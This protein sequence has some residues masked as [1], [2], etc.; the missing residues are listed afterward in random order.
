MAENECLDLSHRNSGRWRR[1]N[2][3]VQAKRDPTEVGAKFERYLYR[4]VRNLVKDVQFPFERLTQA[5][6]LGDLAEVHRIVREVRL[7]REYAQLFERFAS[8]LNGAG[9]REVCGRWL[10]AIVHRF[11][12]QFQHRATGAP[13]W[14]DLAEF[15]P[16]RRKVELSLGPRIEALAIKLVSNPTTPPRLPRRPAVERDANQKELLGQS[17]INQSPARVPVVTGSLS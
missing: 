11:F 5:A 9:A 17:L 10:W 7:H 2:G 3:L 16:Y 12:D 6:D 14:R 4:L 8:P 13:Q 1:L 15:T